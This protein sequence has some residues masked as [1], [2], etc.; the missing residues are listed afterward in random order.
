MYLA[1]LRVH[2]TPSLDSR[3]SDHEIILH[4]LIAALGISRVCV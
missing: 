4:V 3:N 1:R 2:P